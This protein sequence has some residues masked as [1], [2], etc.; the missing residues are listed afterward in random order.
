MMAA[1]DPGRL[2]QIAIDLFN[3][4][5]YA[6]YRREN[7]LRADDLLVRAKLCEVL[8]AARV[9]VQ[10]AE[11]AYRRE[12]LPAPSREKPRPDAGAVREAQ[13]LEA[14]GR[15]IGT[16]EGHIRAL[17]VPEDDQMAQR[18]RREA[19]MLSRLLEADEMMV[20]QAEFL[21]EVLTGV[22]ARW[23]LEH[24]GELQGQVAALAKGVQERRDL[25][26]F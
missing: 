22:D 11:Q 4:W 6:F 21:R 16:V 9:S 17:P 15:A 7:R 25:L 20:G 8:A 5:G 10:A 24:A 23:V 12:F 14:L 19:E 2:K 26:A 3:G 13:V 1:P 18:F